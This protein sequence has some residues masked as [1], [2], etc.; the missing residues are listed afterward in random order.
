MAWWCAAP[1]GREL[2]ATRLAAAPFASE[3]GCP[4]AP[5]WS[6]PTHRVRQPGPGVGDPRCGRAGLRRH[7]DET[8]AGRRWSR[9]GPDRGLSAARRGRRTRAQRQPLVP[10]PDTRFVAGGL[11]GSGRGTGPAPVTQRQAQAL[12][13]VHLGVD[14][15]LGT[16]TGGGAGGRRRRTGAIIRGRTPR[17][18]VLPDRPMYASFLRFLAAA[19]RRNVHYSLAGSIVS[20]MNSRSQ[21]ATPRACCNRSGARQAAHGPAGGG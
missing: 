19:F 13:P 1:V 6:T 7:V 14:A 15:G 20:M 11:G 5:R 2:V 12:V 21:S 18:G 10:L 16:G 8:G 3:A 9:G 4:G 17:C